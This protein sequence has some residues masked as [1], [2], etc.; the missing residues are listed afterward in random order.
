M[1]ISVEEARQMMGKAN[2]KY[3]DEQIEK[4]VNIF[5]FMADMAIDCFL[6]KRKKRMT[7]TKN[8]K[9]IETKNN[10]RKEVN[11]EKY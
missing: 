8:I 11:Y 5:E 7:D 1:I 4:V 6:V 2:K 10:D 3:N 9:A